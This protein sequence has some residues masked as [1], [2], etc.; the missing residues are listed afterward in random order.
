MNKKYGNIEQNS[1]K[2]LLVM[3]KSKDLINITKEQLKLKHSILQMIQKRVILGISSQIDYD[4]KALELKSI[5]QKLIKLQFQ[6][7]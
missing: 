6:Q 7:T 2:I 4:R 3:L 1:Y 5:N